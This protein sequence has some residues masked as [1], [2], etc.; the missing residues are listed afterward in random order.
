MPKRDISERDLRNQRRREL[1]RNARKQAGRPTRPL[2]LPE[3]LHPY[4]GLDPE[5]A[6]KMARAFPAPMPDIVCARRLR[7]SIAGG[8]KR[9]KDE[10][11]RYKRSTVYLTIPFDVLYCTGMRAGDVVM[12]SGWAEPGII[13]LVRIPEAI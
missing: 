7:L 11:G 2:T 10:T 8:G 13:R 4:M 3:E 6:A 1:I 5:T 9:N 12:V